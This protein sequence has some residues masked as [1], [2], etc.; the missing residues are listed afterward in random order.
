MR[1]GEVVDFALNKI[2]GPASTLPHRGLERPSHCQF[3]PDQAL[4]LV[5]SG[6]ISLAPEKGGVR[7][8][9]GT[10]AL[11]RFRRT[12]GPPGLRPPPSLVL[13]SYLGKAFA[14]VAAIVASWG[15]APAAAQEKGRTR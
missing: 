10:G 8:Q 6:Q 5:D 14:A 11:W 7:V 2:Q 1:T 13:P 9:Q 3:G 4:Y 12:T 15:C